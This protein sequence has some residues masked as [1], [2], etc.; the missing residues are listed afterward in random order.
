MEVPIS[1]SQPNPLVNVQEGTISAIEEMEGFRKDVV[2]SLGK[3]FWSRK[4]KDVVKKGAKRTKEGTI[5]R[6][7]SQ[8]IWKSDSSETK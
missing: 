4:E 6:V 8:I 5:K 2:V 3:Y 1:Q 7:P